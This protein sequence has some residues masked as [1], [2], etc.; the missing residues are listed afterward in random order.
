VI[1]QPARVLGVVV[2]TDRGCSGMNPSRSPTP[3]PMM[4]STAT[5]LRPAW[6]R[7]AR[8]WWWDTSCAS[9][10]SPVAVDST[11]PASVQVR[12][13]GPCTACTCRPVQS[14]A[15]RRSVATGGDV[16]RVDLRNRFPQWPNDGQPAVPQ[17]VEVEEQIRHEVPAAQMEQCA[18]G[19]LAG[20][21]QTRLDP[22]EAVNEARAVS[23]LRSE[24]L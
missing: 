7:S 6:R 22:G 16:N 15:S 3:M 8:S 14:S 4:P 19:V 11:A 18:A 9:I 20:C 21:V 2:R 17:P 5:S 10:D 1:A 23:Q 13:A 24:L 12:C